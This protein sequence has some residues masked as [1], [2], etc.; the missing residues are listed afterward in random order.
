MG[1]K[2]MLSQCCSYLS[3]CLKPQI[4]YLELSQID[5]EYEFYDPEKDPFLK[6]SDAIHM[7]VAKNDSDNESESNDSVESNDSEESISLFESAQTYD[8]DIE[9]EQLRDEE[10]D[11]L[12]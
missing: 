1:I 7:G 4:A 2:K 12:I 8:R 9:I 5:K 10:I 3:K 11:I 6:E